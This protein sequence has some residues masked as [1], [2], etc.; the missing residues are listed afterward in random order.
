MGPFRKHTSVMPR[1]KK[2]R[3]PGHRLYPLL[4]CLLA[5]A[6]A[7]AAAAAAPAPADFTAQAR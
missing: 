6:P 2:A 1:S 3:P 4:S 7:L 5:M